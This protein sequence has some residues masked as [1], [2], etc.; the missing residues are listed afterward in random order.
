MTV[1]LF[2]PN[3]GKW[4][5]RPGFFMPPQAESG[6]VLF[7]LGEGSRRQWAFEFNIKT[8]EP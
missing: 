3:I 4:E 2:Y 7:T 1:Y 8:R 6:A 5:F